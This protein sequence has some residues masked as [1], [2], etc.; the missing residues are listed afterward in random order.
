MNRQETS[1]RVIA[2]LKNY[3][4]DETKKIS[5]D[6]Q[7]MGDLGFD[8]LKLLLMANDAEDEFNVIID[9]AAMKRLLTVGDI[10]DFLEES[11]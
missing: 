8:S 11:A 2:F 4:D 7:L 3:L 1:D 5:E 10:I 9:D 6:S